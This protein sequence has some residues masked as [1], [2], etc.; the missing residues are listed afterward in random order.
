[1]VGTRTEKQE[2]AQK[3]LDRSFEA[4]FI[5]GEGDPRLEERTRNRSHRRLP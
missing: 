1:M 2:A 5:E 3:A 4:D